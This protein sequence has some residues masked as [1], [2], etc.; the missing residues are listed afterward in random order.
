[1]K[2][3]CISKCNNKNLLYW[4]V[5]YVNWWWIALDSA[6]SNRVIKKRKKEY[7]FLFHK[8]HTEQKKATHTH[9]MCAFAAMKWL[10][11]Q[12]SRSEM[13]FQVRRWQIWDQKL[14]K[15]ETDRPKQKN[16]K[17]QVKFMHGE[18]GEP[19]VSSLISS[20]LSIKHLKIFKTT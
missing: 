4:L 13:S 19:W 17:K 6:I 12:K 11:S 9:N 7:I 1:M 16:G 18:D 3:L 10:L 8:K 14:S 5:F 15:E 20:L 2:S